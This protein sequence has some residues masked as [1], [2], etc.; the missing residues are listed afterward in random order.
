LEIKSNPKNSIDNSNNFPKY[1]LKAVI[2]HFGNQDS[3]HFISDIFEN[4]KWISCN[5]ENLN[6]INDDIVFGKNRQKS[7]YIFVYNII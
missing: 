1:S 3:G 4:G 7:G 2:S 6:E 5:D